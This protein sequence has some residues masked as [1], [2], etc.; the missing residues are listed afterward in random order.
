GKSYHSSSVKSCGRKRRRRANRK[1]YRGWV[2]GGRL[3]MKS[4][5][6]P[7]TGRP[8]VS[9]RP[10]LVRPRGTALR[11][12]VLRRSG[13]PGTTRKRLNATPVVE[14]G[15]GEK[16]PVRRGSRCGKCQERRGRGGLWQ[17]INKFS[18]RLEFCLND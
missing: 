8:A 10:P 17:I 16:E 3:K 4:R 14:R 11:P 18:C 15:G 7:V 13:Q 12:Q 1:R 5:A 6:G 2:G 9:D